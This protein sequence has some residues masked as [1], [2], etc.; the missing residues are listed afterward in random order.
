MCYY[1]VKLELWQLGQC[2]SS[3]SLQMVPHHKCSSTA[4]WT[5]LK[6][7]FGLRNHYIQI[8]VV[9]HEFIPQIW[10]DDPIPHILV[11]TN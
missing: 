7:V 2:W 4:T 3:M 9:H 6:G 10:W 11:L 1:Y 8:E 5:N